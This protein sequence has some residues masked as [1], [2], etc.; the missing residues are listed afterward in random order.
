[1]EQRNDKSYRDWETVT[2]FDE[3]WMAKEAYVNY[4]TSNSTTQTIKTDKITTVFPA[5]NSLEGYTTI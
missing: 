2:G 4:L 3:K 1:M 5:G